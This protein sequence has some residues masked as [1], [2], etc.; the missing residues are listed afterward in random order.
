[1]HL[2]PR[3]WGKDA[4]LDRDEQREKNSALKFRDGQPARDVLPFSKN[5]QP[6]ESGSAESRLARCA[7]PCLMEVVAAW[8]RK[9]AAVI[10]HQRR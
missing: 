4:A 10:E 9:A 2:A 3:R 6:E 1:M 8:R 5:I 7:L